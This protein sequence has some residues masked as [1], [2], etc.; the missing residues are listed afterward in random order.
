MASLV[1]ISSQNINGFA[2]NESFVNGLCDQYPS[3]IR[4][5][6]EHWMKPPFKKHQGVNKLKHVHA[7]FDGWGTS[8]MRSKMENE[9]RIGRP[10]GGTGFMWN[11]KFSIAIKPR[12]E[13]KHERVTVLE[14]NESNGKILLINAYM[15]YFNSSQAEDQI[16]LYIETLGF[17]D[18]V[19]QMNPECSF[20]LLSDLNCNIYDHS[21]PFT[22][23][24]RDL[25]QKR[26]LISTYDSMPNFDPSSSW[27]RKGIGHNGVENHT[28]IDYILVSKSLISCVQ[29]V[30]I[31]D[32]TGNLSDHLPV[33]IDLRINLSIYTGKKQSFPRTVNWNNVKGEIR[34]N[35]E[36]I[37]ERELDSISV[38]FIVHGMTTCNNC[39]HLHLIE[40]Y[41]HRLT[42]AI[43]IADAVLPRSNPSAQKSFWN[44]DLS[45]LKRESID[46]YNLWENA[47]KPSSGVLFDL[48][49]S[50]HYRYKIYL[51]RCQKEQQTEK[52]DLMHEHLL[53]TNYKQ[54]WK[55][56]KSLHGSAFNNPIR[57]DG[58][59]K[60]ED[61][62]NCFADSF[63]TVY[64]SNDT[65]RVLELGS[66]FDD[67]YVNYCNQHDNDDIRGHFITW[68]DMLDIV[69]KMK[70][71]KSAAGF[72]RYEHILY[73]SPKLLCHLHIL[74]NA[75]IQ[76]GYVPYEFLNG[77]ISPIVKNPEGDVSSTE[78]YRG[79]TLSVVF[80]S[81]FEHIILNKIAHLLT[82]DHLQYGYKARHS[83]AHALYV[84]RSCIDYFT[85]HG[86]NVF[87]AFLDCSKGFDKVD[88]SGIFIKL[89]QRNVPLCLLNVIMFWYRKLSSV[90]KWN[91]VYSRSFAVTSGVRQGGVLSPR[92]FLL[93]VDDLINALRK[94]GVGC[95]I[96]DMFVAA[97]M[98]ADDLALLAPT[99]SSLQT[100]LDI[101][102]AYG[103]Q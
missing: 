43:S 58:H 86:S 69:C 52:S 30:R 87:V 57:I 4:A 7:E 6:Q 2:R 3:A 100:L 46:A 27:T 29:N 32:Y 73:G 95:H 13:Y 78:N 63:E 85:E 55:S 14:I 18:S 41:Y 42:N 45:R 68:S 37:M 44:E 40:N 8:A 54:F 98:Y 88:H 15:P 82:S 23:Y 56:W 48:K 83:T 96:I 101:C 79:I 22:S 25:M 89:L 84:L 49:K 10:F 60:D 12:L 28:L 35:Y 47:G 102:Y 81:L 26:D 24:V 67:L 64:K 61:V 92:L 36:M 34:N 75:L 51:R 50:A 90:V 97:I 16:A 38:P 33:E 31:S 94:S 59:F 62:A 71:G 77:V 74:Y 65:T 70:T 76:H 53:D 72:I 103:V 11:K 80:A 9:V 39:E 21:H 1:T 91:N 19:M 99:R 5:F 93:Y 17:I 20:I 66:K